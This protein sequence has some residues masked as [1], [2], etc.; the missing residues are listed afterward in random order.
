[1]PLAYTNTVCPR[2][3]DYSAA[4]V[5]RILCIGDNMPMGNSNMIAS[6]RKRLGWTQGQ[7][8]EKLGVEQPTVQRWEKG[9][10]EPDMSKL[11]EIATALGVEP[12]EL[13][14]INTVIPLGPTL[15]V[16]GK[17]AAGV[18]LEAT[19]WPE[20]EWQSFTGRPDVT[21]QIA[22]RFGLRV[23]GE[24]MNLLYPPGSV[25]ECVSVFGHTEIAP[26]KRVVVV[27][28]REDR[29]FEATV[30]ELVQDGDGKMWAVPRSSDPSFLPINLSDPEP[31]IIETRIAAVVVASYRPE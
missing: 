1:M 5:S 4:V 10:R 12:G 26:G 17:V 23:E 8:A 15:H 24:S 28:E 7:L 21:A 11:V 19:E 9:T 14:G 27:R 30:K 2:K 16:K 6:L 29:R 20:D 18:W 22:S 25:V 31:G 13:F 3:P